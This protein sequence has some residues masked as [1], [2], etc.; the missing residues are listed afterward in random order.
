MISVYLVEVFLQVG[1]LLNYMLICYSRVRRFRRGDLI[2]MRLWKSG[3]HFYIIGIIILTFGIALSIQSTLGTSPFDALLVGLH[4]TI[5]LTIGSWEIVVGAT[6]VVC[7][8]LIE[9]KRPQYFAIITS[10]ITGIGIDLW[11]LW[12]RVYV[13]PSTMLGKWIVLT[14]AFLAVSLGIAIYL[15]ST[16]APNPIDKT[17]VI[18]MDKTGWNATYARGVVNVVLVVIAFFFN[19]PIGIGT[20]INALLLGMII[21]GFLP[22]AAFLRKKSF[23][24]EM[25][26]ENVS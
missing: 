11:M 17:M 25:E 18:I 8:A 21:G 23:G 10:L 12:A 16:I 7:N 6:F 4:R 14:I 24:R 9:K 22:F 2:M 19:G 13:V 15:Q 5:G 3:I 26:Q 1:I 20:L